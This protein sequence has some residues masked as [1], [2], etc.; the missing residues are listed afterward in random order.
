[1]VKAKFCEDGIVAIIRPCSTLQH[2]RDRVISL[3]MVSVKHRQLLPRHQRMMMRRRG[4]RHEGDRY[5]GDTEVRC[6]NKLFLSYL[7]TWPATRSGEDPD[8]GSA[9]VALDPADLALSLP[10]R[11]A[12][13]VD[14]QWGARLSLDT[15][16][17]PICES[18]TCISVRRRLKSYL[19][20]SL[21]TALNSVSL[22][23][24][25]RYWM[26]E[27]CCPEPRMTPLFLPAPGSGPAK[28]S[29]G[30]FPQTSLARPSHLQ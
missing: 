13:W 15:H 27:M 16:L 29:S 5:D 30:L 1:M 25:R 21:Y 8:A 24:S 26:I 3:A 12:R 19:G 17:R 11:V 23:T 9:W 20:T 22:A 28:A 14:R 4:K 10:P 7:I 2:R 18:T 6:R